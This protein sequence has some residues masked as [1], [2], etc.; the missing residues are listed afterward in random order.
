MRRVEKG[1]G[2]R[3]KDSVEF[4]IFP[5]VSFLFFTQI[6]PSLRHW[7]SLEKACSVTGVMVHIHVHYQVI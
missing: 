4:V 7:L 3:G 5:V 1:L 2:K 6:T